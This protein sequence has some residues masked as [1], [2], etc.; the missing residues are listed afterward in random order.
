MVYPV[1][2]GSTFIVSDPQVSSPWT[3]SKT[4]D[5]VEMFVLTREVLENCQ[6]LEVNQLD[7]SVLMV[8][9]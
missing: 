5:L 1:E 8:K 9:C 4:I 2:I 7:G 6:T 3:P